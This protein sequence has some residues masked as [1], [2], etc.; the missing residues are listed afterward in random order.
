MMGTGND[1]AKTD[2]A[3]SARLANIEE[4]QKEMLRRAGTLKTQTD[5]N[6]GLKPVLERYM[7]HINERRAEAVKL[8][9]YLRSML[10]SLNSLE[11]PKNDD[12]AKLQSDQNVIAF[13]IDRWSKILSQLDAVD[14]IKSA[15]S[16]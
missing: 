9:Q 12:G 5:T 15:A 13:E 7:D 6:P 16:H 14:Q 3:H 10:L 4:L 11:L 1:I 8:L 2:K